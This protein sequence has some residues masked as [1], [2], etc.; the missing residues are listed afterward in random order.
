MTPQE[1]NKSW[2]ALQALEWR[3]VQLVDLFYISGS[4]TTP[5][6]ELEKYGKGD[7][8]YVT[9]QAINNGI[10]GYYNFWTE[11]GDCLTID[12]A[13]LGTCFYQPRNFSASDHVEILRPK[14]EPFTRNIALYFVTA[15]NR[16]ALCHGYSYARKRSQRALRE[17]QI[18]LPHTPTG[19]IAFEAMEAFIRELQAERLEELQAYLKVTNLENTA[20]TP[21]E[22]EALD[23]FSG[24][25]TGG[26]EM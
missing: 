25:L 15:L 9:T 5:K 21:L 2:Q 20:L 3:G 8:P 1:N 12:S 26:G 11:K 13:V 10:A 7:Y 17:E 4:K 16:L 23:L 19:K 22:Q 18:P 14:F 24:Y 6:L